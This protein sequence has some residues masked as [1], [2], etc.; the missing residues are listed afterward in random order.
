VTNAPYLHLEHYNAHQELNHL[1][2]NAPYLHLEHY[3]AHQELNHLVTNAPYLQT[4]N[5]HQA[6]IRM[7]DNVKELH[8]QGVEMQ[9]VPL[10]EVRLLVQAAQSGMLTQS[11][12]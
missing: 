7:Q 3:N 5:A 1:V 9:T 10:N 6:P 8:V 11:K 4:K 12:K 2:T